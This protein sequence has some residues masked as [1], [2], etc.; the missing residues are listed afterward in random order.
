VNSELIHYT[1]EMEAA[2]AARREEAKRLKAEIAA[3]VE[4]HGTRPFDP[5]RHGM[6]LLGVEPLVFV[7]I[8]DLREEVA[9]ALA[10]DVPT[11]E[12][13]DLRPEGSDYDDLTWATQVAALRDAWPDDAAWLPLLQELGADCLPVTVWEAL[14]DARRGLLQEAIIRKIASA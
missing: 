2:A 8:A 5:L 14:Q 9:S 7:D 4:K 11:S 10:S 6:S 3:F 1:P 12:V 13:I